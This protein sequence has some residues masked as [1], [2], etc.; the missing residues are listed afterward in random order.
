[1]RQRCT[2]LTIEHHHPET[3]EQARDSVFKYKRAESES[4]QHKLMR[5]WIGALKE[6]RTV[7]SSVSHLG[8]RNA[9]EESGNKIVSEKKF[10]LKEYG[11]YELRTNEWEA[12]NL[13][14][15]IKVDAM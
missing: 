10:R 3:H 5:R 14:F 9:R 1:M 15:D 13:V 6:Y 7:V 8:C 4:H 12:G 11:I 2:A